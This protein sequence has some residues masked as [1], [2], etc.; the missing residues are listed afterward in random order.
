MAADHL[1]LEPVQLEQLQRLRVVA[2]RD[3][4]LVAALLAGSRSAAGTRARAPLAV[5]SIQTFMRRA[6]LSMPSGTRSAGGAL[7][8]VRSCQSV[9]ASRPQSCRL[10]SCAP[11][12]V[13]VEQARHRLRLEEALRRSV[14]GESVSRANGSSSPRSHAAAGIEKPRLRPCTISRGSERRGRLAQQHLL[15]EPAHL[16]LRPAART[17]SSSRP[18]RGTARAPRASAPSTR[19]RSSRAG[20]RRGRCRSRRPAAARAGRR[21]RSRRSARGRRRRGSNAAAPCRAS[22]ARSVRREDLLPAVVALERRQVRGADEALRL[23][24][25]ARL[26]ASS[27]GRRSTS[28]RAS[29]ASGATRSASRSAAYV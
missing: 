2:R 29:R 23:V 14:S 11:G 8:D 1:G 7:L 13:L 24:V 21:P 5:M 19:G 6:A 16:V 3:L 22:S 20:R 18:G 25:E 12:D 9:N 26:R 17:R 27:V 4:D 10:Q 15:R 28:G